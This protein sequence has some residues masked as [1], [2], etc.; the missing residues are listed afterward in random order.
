MCDG[1]KLRERKK[2][3]TKRS[4]SNRDKCIPER[5]VKQST[6]KKRERWVWVSAQRAASHRTKDTGVLV[7]SHFWTTDISR[8]ILPGLR[9]KT[10]IQ[11][12]QSP[13]Q[14]KVKFVFYLEIKLP[15]SGE[16][17]KKFQI[18]NAWSSQSVRIQ[19]SPGGVFPL[20]FESL[21]STNK[22]TPAL[23]AALCWLAVW[24]YWLLFSL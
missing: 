6:L 5:T 2:C 23:H 9:R 12:I 3:D 10:M 14:M 24:R 21:Q 16:R 17:T 4:S 22:E 7:S 11:M 20:C 18:H 15:E 19:I 13:L 1:R 8:S